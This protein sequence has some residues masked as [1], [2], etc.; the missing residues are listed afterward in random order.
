MSRNQPS[1]TPS[2]HHHIPDGDDRDRRVCDHCGFVDY[3]NPRIIVGSVA[4]WEDRVLLCR[5]A[6]QPRRGFWTLPA[7]FM[8][9]GEIPAEGARR[10][11]W[12][13]ARADL[14]IEQLLGVYSVPH[15]GHV[16]MIYRARLLSDAIAPGPESEEVG[17]FRFDELPEERAFPS[18][19]WALQHYLETR[20]R[21]DFAPRSAPLANGEGVTP[22]L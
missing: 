3:E 2:F 1:L 6:I 18:V 5:R 15:I 16:Q 13:E 11:A 9:K 14:E 21:V 10:E 12:E 8:E 19:T 20:D 4:I 7:G 17:L 22:G